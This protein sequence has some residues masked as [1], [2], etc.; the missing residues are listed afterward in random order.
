[1]GTLPAADSFQALCVSQLWGKRY[2]I[3]TLVTHSARVA[4]GGCFPL[5]WL[6]FLP[7]FNSPVTSLITHGLPV[8]ILRSSLCYPD[9]SYSVLP[10]VNVPPHPGPPTPDLHS[11]NQH[12]RKSESH[13][14]GQILS[15]ELC[16][17]HLPSVTHVFMKELFH[18]VISSAYG[19]NL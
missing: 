2:M 18:H 15:S 7:A 14:P 17:T 5:R 4:D 16:M 9:S 6:S 19:L 10:G 1:M 11:W 12:Q 13:F 8:S 3:A